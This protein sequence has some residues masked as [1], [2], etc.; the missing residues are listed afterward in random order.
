MAAQGL[1][2]ILREGKELRVKRSIRA[3]YFL[4]KYREDAGGVFVSFNTM[5]ERGLYPVPEVR[6][7]Q[8]AGIQ[9]PRKTLNAEEARTRL[10]Q[11]EDMWIGA[12]ERV[13]DSI[14]R[15]MPLSFLRGRFEFVYVMS[16]FGFFAAGIM[17][18]I[19]VIESM[20]ENLKPSA[21]GIFAYVLF[22]IIVGVL[23]NL[24]TA[25]VTRRGFGRK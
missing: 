20:D 12:D 3:T 17:F 13:K 11:F 21:L 1:V 10:D 7:R 18:A 2:R 22:S 23:A 8:F 19:I 25:W 9:E 16:L 5:R 15:Y 24:V 14:T 4:L 6:V